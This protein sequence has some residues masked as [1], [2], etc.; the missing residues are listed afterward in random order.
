MFILFG[1]T[2]SFW[3]CDE[4]AY[5]GGEQEV[6]NTLHFVAAKERRGKDQSSIILFKG[7]P[8]M[9]KDFPGDLSS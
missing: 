8:P 3:A 9:T 5:H 4:A 6:K 2:H 7:T 1:W